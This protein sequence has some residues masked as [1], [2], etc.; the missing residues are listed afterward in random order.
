MVPSKANANPTKA[1]FVRMITRDISLTDCVLDLIDN[2]IDGAWQLEGSP[3]MTL[4]TPTR[5]SDYKIMIEISSDHFKILDNCGGIT[6]DNA[7]E[8]AFTFGRKED[9]PQE[10]YSIGV[11]GIGMKRAVFKMGNII[12]IRSTYKKRGGSVESFAVPI[13]VAKWLRDDKA[14]WDF[15]IEPDQ[16]LDTTGVEIAV[17]QLSEGTTTSFGDPAFLQNLRRTIA[18]DYALH[19]HRGLTITLNGDDISGWDFEMRESRQFAPM[20]VDLKATISETTHGSKKTKGV[21]RITMLAGMAAPP[22]ESSEPDEQGDS[23]SRSGWYIACNGRIVLAADKSSTSGWGTDDWPKW[24]PQYAGFIGL[25]LFSS[26]NASLLPLTTTKR[27]IDTSSTVFRQMIQHMR[28]A[29]KMW[30]TYTNLRKQSLDDA[31]KLE[32]QAKPVAIYEIKKRSDIML[33][34]LTPK[35]K[36][37]MASINYSMPVDRVRSLATELGDIN[38]AYREVGIETFEYVYKELIEGE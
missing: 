6:L 33:P 35:P 23:E 34:A 27:S 20:R 5:L 38:M 3:L 22:P 14:D 31:K 12:R 18:R 24:H 13:N 37:K 17:T 29:S 9:D 7:A 19:L 10:K 32:G 2:S 21:V 4:W 28:S 30:I 1:F 25:V 11:Y 15:D 26:E 36:L 8:Y 16:P